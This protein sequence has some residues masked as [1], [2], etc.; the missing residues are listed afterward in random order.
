MAMTRNRWIKLDAL[1]RAWRSFL[2]ALVAAALVGAID[3]AMQVLSNAL[4]DATRGN[5]VDWKQVGIL[6]GSG[7]L[8]AFVQPF[9]AYAHR[10]W[11]DQSPIPSAAPP[12]EPLPH[13]ARRDALADGELGPGVRVRVVGARL[14][15]P[16]RFGVGPVME[17]LTER[18]G[19][20]RLGRHVH[21]DPASRAYAVEAATSAR[22]R[23]V[24]W[25]RYNAILNQGDTGSCTGQAM[26]GWLGCAPH[27]TPATAAQY[28]EVFAV[29]LYSA[30]T[31]LDNFPGTYP[32]DDNGSSGLA[33][34]KVA[35][36][37]GLISSYGWA[38]TTLGLLHALQ[39]SPVLVG[40]PWF[41]RFDEPDSHGQVHIGGEIRGGHEF[42]IRGYDA[43]A[44]L[45][46]CDNS[47]SERWNAPM[48]GSFS[49][50]LDT[51]A[52]LRE[53]QAD[54]TVPRL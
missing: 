5:A 38:F 54:V 42:L 33:V 39:H 15:Q 31:R 49:M 48:H 44:Q 24:V 19:A 2:H 52:Q 40:V 35:H 32:P 45:L 37:R 50:S 47:W 18:P 25:P 43:S 6:A 27:A 8:T 29:S 20:G 22:P 28:D 10:R 16:R 1:N 12:S 46:L 30:A 3:A 4:L 23:T 41:E 11:L 21:H 26:A 51:W 13:G 36:R 34:A 7:A 17:L 53:Q 9:V 14:G